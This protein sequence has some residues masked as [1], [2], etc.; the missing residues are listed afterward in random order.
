MKKKNFFE[1]KKKKKKTSLA[2]HPSSHTLGCQ[3]KSPVKSQPIALLS[4]E[5]KEKALT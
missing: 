1:K 5:T 3:T 2:I 4:R